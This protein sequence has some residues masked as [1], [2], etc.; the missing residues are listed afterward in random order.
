MT[1]Y[2]LK[3]ILLSIALTFS[4]IADAAWSI[5][6]STIQIN[7]GSG[8]TNYA[9]ARN[10]LTQTAFKNAYLGSFTSGSTFTLNGAYMHMRRTGSSNVCT[11]TM[12][13]RIYKAGSTPGSWIAVA[14]PNTSVV[15]ASTTNYSSSISTVDLLSSL[16]P[17]TY[18]LEVYWTATG[19]ST[20]STCCSS[21]LNDNNGGAGFRAYFD[22]NMFDS[23]TDGNFSAAPVWSG[24]DASWRF[25]ET[26]TAAAGA[27]NSKTL[28]SRGPNSTGTEYLSTP[29]TNWS[30]TEQHWSFWLG[31]NSQSYTTASRVMIWLYANEANLESATVD[32]YRI[33]I[34]DD[35]GGDEFIL[36]VVTNGVA[37]NL[38]TSAALNNGLT[39]I[40]VSIHVKRLTGGV[41]TLYTSTLPTSNGGGQTAFSD[42]ETVATVNQ[43][44]ATNNTY[45]PSG[46]GYFGIV[47]AHTTSNASRNAVDLDG[48]N[49]R[50]VFPAQT[51]VQFTTASTSAAET[52][53]SLVLTLSITNPSV[54]FATNATVTLTSGSSARLGG[55]TSQTVTF[56]ANSSTNRTI[57]IPITNN[58]NCDDLANLVFTISSVSG[59]SSA[60]ANAPSQNNL[61][62]TDDDMEYPVF[63]VEDAESGTLTGWTFASPG[64]WSANSSAPINGV[65][66]A[67]HVS[68]GSSG[69]SYLSIPL[70]DQPL[71][72]GTTT[73][74]FNLSH[75]AIEP[76]QNDKFLFFIA[77]NE[78]NLFSTTVDGYAVG[79]NP[80][81]S[82]SPD[83]ITLWRIENGNPVSAIVTSSVDVGTSHN[84]IGYRIIRNE[85]GSWSMW[86]DIDGGFD[87]MVSYGSGIDVTYDKLSYS[88]LRY[89]FKSTT[90]GQLQFDDL[91]ISQ[92][93]CKSTYY[94]RSTGNAEAAIWSTSPTGSPASV[95]SSRYASFVVQN[96]HTVTTT[97]TWLANHLTIDAGGTLAQGSQE[98]IL[99]GDA[100]INGTWN[101]GTGTLTFKG[102]IDQ[103]LNLGNHVSLY[104]LK[105]D[106]DAT[107][108][109]LSASYETRVYG[110]VSINEGQLSTQDML[111]LKSVSYATGSIGEISADGDIDGQ[112]TIERFIPS[113][114]N[115]PYGS[116]M[117]VGCPVIGQTI[118]DWDDDL[119]TTGFI[120]ADYPAPYSF[121]SIAHYDESVAGAQNMGYTH[122]NAVSDA[123]DPERG[124]MVYAQSNSQIIDVTGE[125]Y[126]GSFN[127]N[128]SYTNTGSAD[129]G[130]NLLVN[131]YPSQVDFREMVMNGNG[132]ASYYLFDAETNNFKPYNG[133]VQT[134]T[135]PR[136]INS[137]QSFF[138]KANSSGAYLRYEER[139][140]TNQNVTFERSPEE[141]SFFSF[142]LANENG[143]ADEAIVLFM[144][145]ASPNFEWDYDAEKLFSQQSSALSLATVAANGSWLSVDSRPYHGQDIITVYVN[146]PA[147]GNYNLKVTDV[148]N[149]PAA[150]CIYIEDMTSGEFI[151][152]DLNAELNFTI[153]SPFIGNRFMIHLSPVAEII[154][155]DASCHEVSNGELH[156]SGITQDWNIQLE[157]VSGIIAN[158]SGE[159]HLNN[160]PAGIYQAYFVPTL[161]VCQSTVV[162]ISIDEPS[163]EIVSVLSETPDHCNETMNGS[164]ELI[165]ENIHQ[166]DYEIMNSSGDVILSGSSDI[167]AIL[168]DQLGAD[169][170][171]IVVNTSCESHLAEVN[172]KDP[173]A[174]QVDIN[175]ENL[176]FFT[177]EGEDAFVQITANVTNA[178]SFEWTLD[179]GF[180]SHDAVF[181]THIFDAGEYTLML[182]ASNDE[183]QAADFAQINL[184]NIVDTDENELNAYVSMIQ[185]ENNLSFSF[186]QLNPSDM[187]IYVH[188]TSGKLVW[189]DSGH[190]EQGSVVDADVTKLAKGVYAV[191]V[192]VNNR[193][194]LSKNFVR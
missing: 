130:W 34:G 129:D 50:A 81:N 146:L 90:S 156:I 40:G 44:S 179:N 154:S 60:V 157:N 42:A 79:I 133:I 107:Q 61:T 29:H 51:T 168:A 143:G 47:S 6:Q 48:I 37:T 45:T 105:I 41:W 8:V 151:P 92:K 95:V 54:L 75:F 1:P 115:Y 119:I 55:F 80:A 159:M 18:F 59:G 46:T 132:V 94:S 110:V 118:A 165:L 126:K 74:Q 169:I 11:G 58:S 166:Y 184:N 9:G 155:S 167:D 170:Y 68:T 76:D 14:L 140:K 193:P 181:S 24:D 12:Y 91:T 56:P 23:F 39:D 97:D 108:V 120:G 106:N 173:L 22:Y 62:L 57:T 101:A 7:T 32:G 17:A 10:Y 145:E 182:V 111:V 19:H 189:S 86:L 176:N 27:T 89:V 134:G 192:L 191:V 69:Q 49:I 98:C 174:I 128:L 63:E 35:S 150:S 188:D 64:A 52:D 185:T 88:G 102:E 16:T 187:K 30:A 137:S 127:K 161:D 53:G 144:D 163:Q 20:C 66:S 177:D 141:N 2:T 31:R 13:Y 21:V 152:M 87:N 117:A 160:L 33:L 5:R 73:W 148:N 3:S 135:A 100:S 93:G 85:S 25:L 28:R 171:S 116:W 38:I 4:L 122:V 70:D 96:S 65:Y 123:L 109:A 121:N 180:V 194:I 83:I 175:D 172:L 113:L 71:D 153:E 190:A 124:Y 67:R 125:I 36:Q 26:S 99:Y 103:S 72:G 183:C 158:S 104:N 147:A 77:A 78:S 43:G 136:Y 114:T 162:E 82:F 186:H 84:E 178:T 112:V 164:F 142:K 138:V 139:F 131:Q 149:L 15:D